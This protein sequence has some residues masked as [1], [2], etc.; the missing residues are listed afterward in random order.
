MLQ[1]KAFPAL[2]GKTINLPHTEHF[3]DD[4]NEYGIVGSKVVFDDEGFAIVTEA[5]AAG[6]EEFYAGSCVV[7]GAA[8]QK[9]LKALAKVQAAKA[10]A[11]VARVEA[12]KVEQATARSAN[13]EAQ[14]AQN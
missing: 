12:H 10:K 4:E 11:S 9:A 2:V 8:P 14:A 3:V 6:L 5:Q 1:V 7:I 13:A